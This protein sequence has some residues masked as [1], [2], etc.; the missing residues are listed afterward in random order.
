MPPG[1]PEAGSSRER[2]IEA[3]AELFLERGYAGVTV[4][5]IARQ[6]GFTTGAVY[7]QFRSKEE[8]LSIAVA[9]AIN[10]NVRESLERALPG[11]GAS[12]AAHVLMLDVLSSAL[13]PGD[14]VMMHGLAAAHGVGR[15]ALRPPLVRIVDVIGDLIARGV[16]EGI[17]D[18]GIDRDAFVRVTAALFFG[19][20]ALKML[21]L[22]PADQAGLADVL[23]RFEAGFAPGG[24]S[25]GGRD[26]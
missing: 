20:V 21:E 3:A 24:R 9:R 11:R 2:L 1:D 8:L 4:A 18:P 26:E 23:R 7:G 13:Q 5:A 12:D 19:S 14:V 10:R 15:E 6:A 22:P 17:I 16:E 25:S